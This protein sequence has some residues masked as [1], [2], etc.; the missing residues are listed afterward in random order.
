VAFLA[1]G[2][3]TK[4][5]PAPNFNDGVLINCGL[6][7]TER[8]LFVL[9]PESAERQNR[10][11]SQWL[12]LTHLPGTVLGGTSQHIRCAHVWNAA[13]S[14]FA[15]CFGSGARAFREHEDRRGHGHRAGDAATERSHRRL[16]ALPKLT[17][18]PV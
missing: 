11:Q 16:S 17:E 2:N 9:S 7:S 13:Q 1:A 14:T 10:D 4:G 3:V 12:R 8:L 6:I 15:D 5:R 18:R